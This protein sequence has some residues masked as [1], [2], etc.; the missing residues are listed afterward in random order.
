MK[1]KEERSEEFFRRLHRF[2]GFPEKFSESF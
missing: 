2:E 1:R